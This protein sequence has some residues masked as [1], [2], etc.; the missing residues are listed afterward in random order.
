[1]N[2]QVLRAR[3]LA[4]RVRRGGMRRTKAVGQA[5]PRPHLPERYTEDIANSVLS[6]KRRELATKRSFGPGDLEQLAGLLTMA[7]EVVPIREAFAR[8]DDWPERFLALRHD[9]DHDVENAVRMAE[10][11]AE[12]GFRST[13][14][15]LHGDWY[16]GGPSRTEPSAF[17][18]R[19]LDRIASLGH[20]IGLHN[21]A[22]TLALAT[23][24]DPH[25]ILDR[26]LSALRRHGFEIDGS[27]AHGDP[28]CRK[29]G[30]VNNE[31]F[32]ECPRPEL[33][34]PDRVIAFDDP[35]TKTHYRLELHPRPMADFGLTHEANTIGQT[36]YLTDT[37]GR[38]NP[39][40]EGLQ[41][42]FDA[43]GGFLQM[44][45]HPVWWAFQGEPVKSK[46]SVV[47]V[48][49]PSLALV[50]DPDAAPYHI[51]VR[52]DCCSRRA[53]NMNRDLFG[54][55]PQMVRDEKARTDFF[56][57]HPIV[58]SA[59]RDDV[60]RLLDVDRM[61]ASLRQY[62]LGQTDR[63]TLEATSA[64][65]LVLDDYSDMNFGAWRNKEHGWKLWIHPAF[66]RDREAFEKEFESVGQLSFDESLEAH[67]RL[68]ET[69]REHLGPVPVLYLHQPV[70][71]Y[72]K[73][74]SRDG[75]R[76]LGIELAKALPDVYPADLSDDELEPDD[77]GSCGPGQT[78][79]FTGGTY[80]TMIQGALEKGLSEW[81]PPR[82]SP[83][84]QN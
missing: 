55:N 7:D 48:S 58:G 59:T 25:R 20:E 46:P 38:W 52:G 57:D 2:P 49:E 78:L 60:T 39:P 31:I 27:V 26:D 65:L 70:A 83:P 53:I 17:V 54:G 5:I 35:A 30:Y 36:R 73:L 71:L 29:I 12:H 47:P 84:I 63:T 16:W 11:E 64:R 74:E 19:A 1:M 33:G 82:Q 15:V 4:G 34:G 80:R 79:H 13:Y 23:G 76:R 66:L 44:L 21:N 45:V 32:D 18:L 51:V 67:V 3:R 40:F 22:I 43:E 10:W 37:G 69:Y 56:V 77:M 68:I 28:L 75:F 62:A 72:R 61:G 81:L 8:R 6:A 41:D 50:G 24:E 14:Y 9:M 42:R